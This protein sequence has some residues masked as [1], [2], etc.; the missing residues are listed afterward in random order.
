MSF[1]ASTEG[2]GGQAWAGAEDLGADRSRPQV[3]EEATTQESG[4]VPVDESVLWNRCLDD[5]RIPRKP[6]WGREPSG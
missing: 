4:P 5:G 1:S 3:S 2:K 6:G